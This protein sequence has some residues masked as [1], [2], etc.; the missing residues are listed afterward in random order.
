MTRALAAG[1]L[2]AVLVATL[3]GPPVQGLALVEDTETVDHREIR[4][5]LDQGELEARALAGQPRVDG[6]E[7]AASWTPVGDRPSP[8]QGFE[9]TVVLELA[10]TGRLMLADE[11]S[12]LVLELEGANQSDDG[13]RDR[14]PAA[15]A[16]PADDPPGG[17]DP[18]NGTTPQG[19]PA[20][21]A[22]SGQDTP[23]MP[24]T[25]VPT[26]TTPQDEGSEEQGSVDWLLV[27]L[28]VSLGLVAVAPTVAGPIK[29]RLWQLGSV[30]WRIRRRHQRRGPRKP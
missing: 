22:P 3:A 21:G 29:R 17:Q 23:E 16:E 30:L 10:G 15:T 25:A 20:P 2:L 12:G 1:V 14:D 6:A 9:R 11:A 24:G 13:S 8:W 27:V 4:V 18:I 7:L 5:A 19:T 26:T 28:V